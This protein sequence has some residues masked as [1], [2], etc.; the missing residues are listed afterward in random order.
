MGHPGTSGASYVQYVAV[1]RTVAPP[2]LA[3]HFSEKFVALPSWHVTDYRFSHA[4]EALGTPPA[5]AP[6]VGPRMAWPDGATRDE[7]ENAAPGGVTAAGLPAA[8]FV[9]A[10]F[11]QLYKAR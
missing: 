4:F 7:V 3:P 9:M 5:G 11:N 10:T 1:D 2:R 8:A 6:P